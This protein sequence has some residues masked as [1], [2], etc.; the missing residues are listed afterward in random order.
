VLDWNNKASDFYKQLGATFR[1][2]W[3]PVLLSDETLRRLEE[4]AP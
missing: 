4:K 3:R 1:D 2:Q